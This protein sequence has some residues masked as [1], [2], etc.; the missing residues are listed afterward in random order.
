MAMD[1][2]IWRFLAKKK[3]RPRVQLPRDLL[4]GNELDRRVMCEQRE[5]V[6]K[7]QVEAFLRAETA[8]LEAR[9]LNAKVR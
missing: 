5:Q 1:H 6:C 2:A 9:Q 3:T 7:A 4:R 8:W